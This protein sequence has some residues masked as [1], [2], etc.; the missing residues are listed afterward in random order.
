L[1]SFPV[2]LSLVVFL[3]KSITFKQKFQLGAG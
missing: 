1:G 3:P 2:L